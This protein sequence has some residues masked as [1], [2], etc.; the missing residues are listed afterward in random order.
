VPLDKPQTNYRFSTT[1][2][3]ELLRYIGSRSNAGY[4]RVRM[5]DT[6]ITLST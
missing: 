1:P 4:A 6:E 5:G 2:L 3:T